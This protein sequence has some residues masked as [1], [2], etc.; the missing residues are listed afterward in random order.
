LLLDNA[1]F[2]SRQTSNFGFAGV[3]FKGIPFSFFVFLSITR[4]MSQAS[5]TSSCC[6]SNM[7]PKHVM[8]NE[9]K[10]DKVFLAN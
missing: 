7:Q 5:Y 9:T 10:I 3:I 4:K 6:F 1:V 8:K 2:F